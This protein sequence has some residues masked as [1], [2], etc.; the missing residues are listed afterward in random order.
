MVSPCS[1]A[2]RLPKAEQGKGQR[3]CRRCEVSKRQRLSATRAARRCARAERYDTGLYRNPPHCG[4]QKAKEEDGGER[5]SHQ[6]LTI[7]DSASLITAERRAVF[8]SFSFSFL[9]L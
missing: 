6:P 9:L 8:P 2:G 3:A 4:R 7:K 1:I 5:R